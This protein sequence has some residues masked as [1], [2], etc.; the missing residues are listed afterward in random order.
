MPSTCLAG[1]EGC[2]GFNQLSFK[3]NRV[4][5]WSGDHVCRAQACSASQV[6]SDVMCSVLLLHEAYYANSIVNELFPICSVHV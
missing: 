1:A 2:V 6:V 4:D 5:I 3:R